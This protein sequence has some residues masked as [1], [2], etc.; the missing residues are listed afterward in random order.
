MKKMAVLSTKGSDNMIYNIS[1]NGNV[2]DVNVTECQFKAV[3]LYL[4]S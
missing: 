1:F 2:F 4:L 3:Y